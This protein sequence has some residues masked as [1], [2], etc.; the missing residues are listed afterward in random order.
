L[1]L[2]FIDFIP[3]AKYPA[4]DIKVKITATV[5]IILENEIF[6]QPGILS[7]KG[8]SAITHNTV[9]IW[10]KVVNFPHIEGVIGISIFKK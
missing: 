5:Q 8:I 2:A 10:K 1:S 9:S 3:L 4:P 6:C 7:E